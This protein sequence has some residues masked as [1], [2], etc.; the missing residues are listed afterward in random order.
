MIADMANAPR[1]VLDP[2]TCRQAVRHLR[3]SDPVLA[4]ILDAVGP[5]GYERRR[6]GTPFAHL[7]RAILY[8]QI[9]GKAAASIHARL[10]AH[11]G[12]PWPRPEDIQASSDADLRAVGLSR[13]KIVYLRDLSQKALAGLPL[14]RLARLDDDAVVEALTEVKG[15]GRWTAHMY[16]IFR[17]GRPDVLP[18]DDYGVRKAMQ[19]AYRRR[20]LPGPEWMRRR[21]E[22]WRPYRSLACWY[23]WRSL[24]IKVP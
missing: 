7:L 21:A 22:A 15:I 5:C 9:S 11:V 8:Q 19:R 17:L 18:V 20:E 3:R 12:R 24:D 4:R 2:A 13:Q 6:G 23:L 10:V 14:T 1:E 16:L